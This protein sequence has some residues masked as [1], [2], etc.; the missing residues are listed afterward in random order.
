MV[1]VEVNNP[2]TPKY[3]VEFFFAAL[4]TMFERPSMQVLNIELGEGGLH[5]N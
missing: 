2:R 5:K 4:P 3:N 1:G